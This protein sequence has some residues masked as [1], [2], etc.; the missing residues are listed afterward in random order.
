MATRKGRTAER[1]WKRLGME[2]LSR[3]IKWIQ[4]LLSRNDYFV[5]KWRHTLKE[6]FFT[7]KQS[8]INDGFERCWERERKWVKENIEGQ[9]AFCPKD[10]LIFHITPQSFEADFGKFNGHPILGFHEDEHPIMECSQRSQGVFP[11]QCLSPCRKREHTHGGRPTDLS[12]PSLWSWRSSDDS[13][14]INL[15][16]LEIANS[17]SVSLGNFLG[18]GKAIVLTQDVQELKIVLSIWLMH[19]IFMAIS[20]RALPTFRGSPKT[21]AGTTV[22]TRMVRLRWSDAAP[23]VTACGCSATLA[24]P[25][26]RVVMSQ[27]FSNHLWLMNRLSSKVRG[28]GRIVFLCHKAFHLSK[29]RSNQNSSQ[30]SISSFSSHWSMS[31]HVGSKLAKK[32]FL[33]TQFSNTATC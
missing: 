8:M 18:D 12:L 32:H 24:L 10:K 11:T 21:A 28:L 27:S 26:L 15:F 7:T 1:C 20:Q 13:F 16:W 29:I 33:G 31:M 25:G 17:S 3:H 30:N 5:G 14:C 2:C 19:H 23:L 22:F 9:H 6:L 4:W